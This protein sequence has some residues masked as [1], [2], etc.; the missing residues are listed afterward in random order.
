MAVRTLEGA[1]W[2]PDRPHGFQPPRLR[3]GRNGIGYAAMQRLAA[4]ALTDIWP[5]MGQTEFLWMIV[6]FVFTIISLVVL[7]PANAPA[8]RNITAR[9]ADSVIVFRVFVILCSPSGIMR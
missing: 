6:T 4:Q 3:K 2:D 5:F 7:A 8:D 1:F 9:A